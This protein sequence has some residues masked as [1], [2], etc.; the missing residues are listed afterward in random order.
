MFEDV[1]MRPHSALEWSSRIGAEP[2]FTARRDY[3]T[4]PCT[5]GCNMVKEPPFTLY[6]ITLYCVL[7]LTEGV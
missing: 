6:G 7:A 2:G 1:G 3:S 4:W 5:C